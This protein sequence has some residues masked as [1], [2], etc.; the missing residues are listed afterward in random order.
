MARVNV[1]H[2]TE[3]AYRNP[4]GPTRHRMMVRPRDSHDL[5]LYDA[6]PFAR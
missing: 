1:P 3:Y 6:R 5:R 4:V 2:T